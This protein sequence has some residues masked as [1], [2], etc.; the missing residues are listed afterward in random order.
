MALACAPATEHAEGGASPASQT[1]PAVDAGPWRRV[2]DREALVAAL[3]EAGT[4]P[5]VIDVGAT[6][7]APCL[8]LERNTLADA[9]VLAALRDHALVRVDVSAGTPAQEGMQAF[10]DALSL[11]RLLVFDDA[12]A[13]REALMASA[14]QAPRARV[15]V[16]TYVDADELLALLGAAAPTP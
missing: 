13:L 7:C 3:R 5:V 1:G 10:F 12:S 8:D 16:K 4:T 11:P 9:R 15:V 14:P 2:H 6:W